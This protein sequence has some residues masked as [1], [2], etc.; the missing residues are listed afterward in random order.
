MYLLKNNLM[1]IQKYFYTHIR[2][3]TVGIV[4]NTRILNI[5]VTHGA[6]VIIIHELFGIGTSISTLVSLL[7]MTFSR[8][9]SIYVSTML[10]PID[11]NALCLS[12]RTFVKTKRTI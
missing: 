11:F 7:L 10:K 12:L 9:S 1:A 5:F 2:V 4:I 8:M 6:C 3:P